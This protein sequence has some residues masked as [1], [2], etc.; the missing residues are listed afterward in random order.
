VLCDCYWD[1][2]VLVAVDSGVRAL[3]VTRRVTPL[4]LQ[5][6]AHHLAAQQQCR[7]SSTKPAAAVHDTAA[8]AQQQQQHQQQLVTEIETGDAPVTVTLIAVT[9]TGT[10]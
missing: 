8:A 10:V 9:A 1:T 2:P 3:H 5:L 7:Q 4:Q 6:L